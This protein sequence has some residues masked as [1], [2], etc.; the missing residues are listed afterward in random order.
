MDV[1][2]LK[3]DR[4]MR[5]LTGLDL[6][7]FC[8]LSEHF[9]QGYQQVLEANFHPV[10]KPQQ[11]KAGAGHKGV[12]ASRE[13]N[14]FFILYYLK[15][16]PTFDVLATNFGLSCSK[17]CEHAHKLALALELTLQNLGVLP[18]RAITYLQQM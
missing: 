1:N 8:Y 17:A 7:E 12:L 15:V 16:Y 10:T 4:Q 13:A 2:L 3:D 18:I 11:G 9:A 5:S 6:A 14:L